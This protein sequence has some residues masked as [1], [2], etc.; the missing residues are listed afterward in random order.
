[1]AIKAASRV[2]ESLSV[3]VQGDFVSIQIACRDLYEA[4]VLFD[5][6][7]ERLQSGESICLSALVEKR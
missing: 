6:L 1:M 5:D 2:G 7:V 3:S 4:Q